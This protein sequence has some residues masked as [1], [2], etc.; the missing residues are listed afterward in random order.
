MSERL[1][2]F[3]TIED[4]RGCSDTALVADIDAVDREVILKYILELREAARIAELG[5]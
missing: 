4:L 5:L 2:I 1:T 3:S